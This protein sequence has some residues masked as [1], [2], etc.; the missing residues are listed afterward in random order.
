VVYIGS[1]DDKVYA[2]NASTGAVKWSYTTGV[3]IGSSPAVANGV[4]YIGSYDDNLYAL[5]T[6][7]GA[8]LWTATTGNFVESSPAVANG[9]VYVG[10]IDSSIYAY[11]LG[12][13]LGPMRPS[14][15]NLHPNYSL[16][17]SA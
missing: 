9:F 6:G 2:V 11:S 17:V 8:V 10:S 14:P 7:S 15:S 1:E 16:K 3:P 12:V 4:I 13:V 5:D